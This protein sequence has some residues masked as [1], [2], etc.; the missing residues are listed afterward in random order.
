MESLC[1]EKGEVNLQ[2][3]MDQLLKRIEF[4]G[5]SRRNFAEKI[6][7][8]RETFRRGLTCEYEMDVAVFFQSIEILFEH[9]T[10]KKKN[11]KRI[12]QYV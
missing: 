1:S 8:S 2:H 11:H 10:E 5:Y 6:K 12:F 7:V 9:P 4:C 3:V